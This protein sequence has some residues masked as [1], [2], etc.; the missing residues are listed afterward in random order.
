MIEENEYTVKIQGLIDELRVAR[1]KIVSL[2][3]KAKREE[4]NG[5]AAHERMMMLE[6]RCRELQRAL[7]NAKAESMA[8]MLANREM[9]LATPMSSNLEVIPESVNGSRFEEA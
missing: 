7:K 6:D 3:D 9:S 1:E 5:G 4:K 8:L 2:E